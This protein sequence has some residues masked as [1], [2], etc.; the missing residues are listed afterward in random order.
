MAEVFL[1]MMVGAGGIAKVAV[2]KR[3]WPELAS[4]PRFLAMFLDEAR[5]SIRMGHPNLVQTYEII[6][7]DGGLAIAMEYLDGQPLGRVLNRLTGPRA[8]SL[9]QRVRIVT[10]LLAALD[11]AHELKDYDGTPLSV[12]HRDVSPSNVFITYDGNVKLV[13]FGIA[14]S[15]AGDHQ[16]WPGT[17]KGKLSYMAPEQFLGQV[18]DRRSD[19]FAVGV[20]LWEMLAGR[21]FWS[22]IAD[23]AIAAQMHSDRSLPAL[24]AELG[25]PVEFEVICARALSRDRNER[26][27]T[28]AQM[29]LD[30]EQVLTS[31]H[32][33]SDRLLGKAVAEGFATERADRQVLI[34]QGL[35]KIRSGSYP[36]RSGSYPAVIGA[37]PT[38]SVSL[39][40]IEIPA[41]A[42]RARSPWAAIALAIAAPTLLLGAFFLGR[43]EITHGPRPM[44]ASPARAVAGHVGP[45]APQAPAWPA[46]VDLAAPKAVAVDPDDSSGSAPPEAPRG[47]PDEP[48]RHSR[49]SPDSPHREAAP[50][51]TVAPSPK[52][53]ASHAEVDVA[54]PY[55][56]PEPR[57]IDMVSPFRPHAYP[58]PRPIDRKSPFKP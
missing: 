46:A 49:R 24:P 20:I 50:A 6:E 34:D 58:P 40:A 38:P 36:F 54:R 28:A 16:T 52:P 1:A 39:P 48:A 12:V 47:R 53:P 26:Y 9:P 57:S 10:K 14:K 37:Y 29:E 44:I 3:I 55:R 13:D 7:E 11:Y 4:D 51:T 35:R 15:V 42:P 21:R 56:P 23:H 19:V 22:G 8:L 17:V 30:L 31:T 27:A 2:L 25:L 18:A 43:G 32:E 33:A 5:L 41:S 45:S